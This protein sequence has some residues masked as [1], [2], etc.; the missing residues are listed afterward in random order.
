ME[1]GPNIALGVIAFI[2]VIA[3]VMMLRTSN[4]VHAALYLMVVLAGVAALF[5][6]L[7]AEFL[8]WTQVLVYIGAVTVLFLFGVMLTKAKLGHTADLDSDNPQRVMGG[9]AAIL[10]F[11]LIFGVFIS[12]FGGGEIVIDPEGLVEVTIEEQ[13][14]I[15]ELGGEEFLHPVGDR[16]FIDSQRVPGVLDRQT[17]TAEIGDLIFERYVLPFEA[18]SIVLL[19]ALIG[20]IVLARRD[21][22]DHVVARDPDSNAP[23]TEIAVGLVAKGQTTMGEVSP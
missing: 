16:V 10:V 17:T 20:S 4:I 5:L 19:A 11:G 12:V 18:I 22:P 23:P 13:F 3:T 14:E 2:I 8:G 15:T 1:V 21:D 9:I 7:G 6:L